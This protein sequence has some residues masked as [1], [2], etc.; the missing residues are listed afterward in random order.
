[1]SA[2]KSK[3]PPKSVSALRVDLRRKNKPLRECVGDAMEEYFSVLDGHGCSGLFEMVMRE[4][5]VP[6]LRS[7]LEHTDGNQTRAS[8]I[9]GLNRSTLRKKLRQ[10]KLL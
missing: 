1:V 10:Y 6:L 2:A 5:E 9:L 3:K 8:E 4:V 7:V